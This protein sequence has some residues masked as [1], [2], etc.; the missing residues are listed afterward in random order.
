MVADD[1]RMASADFLRK[2]VEDGDIE[3]LR[4]GVRGLGQA[5]MELEVS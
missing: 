4:E 1:V 3:L 5:L 2:L